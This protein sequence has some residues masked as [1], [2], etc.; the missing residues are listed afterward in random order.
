M[1]LETE[2]RIYDCN[3]FIKI[4]INDLGIQ[5][6]TKPLSSNIIVLAFMCMQLNIQNRIIHILLYTGFYIIL[7]YLFTYIKQFP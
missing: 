5:I 2:Q 4:S 1:L 6:E 3:R 7:T